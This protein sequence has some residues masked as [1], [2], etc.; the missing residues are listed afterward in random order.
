MSDTRGLLDR[1]SAFRQR[2]DA[3]PQLIPDALLVDP[4]DHIGI[5][6]E[7]ETFRLSL[8]RIAGGDPEVTEKP[9][10][11]PQFT[12]RA[13]RLLARAKELLDR[14]RKFTEDPLF[15]A[16]AG[17][18][19]PDALV[20]YHRE[21]VGVL[22]SSVRLAQ[23]FPDSAGAQLKMCE[24]L[25]GLL[26]VVQDR[27]SIQERVLAERRRDS[28][29]IDRLAGFFAALHC[30]LPTTLEAVAALAEEVLEDA[31]LAK[32]IRFVSAPVDSAHAPGGAVAFPVP[33]RFVAAHALNV[34]QVVARIV[35]FDYEW[36][37]RPLAPVVAAL[38]MDC[39]M[40]TVPSALLAKTD[41]LTPDDRRVLEAHPKLGAELL[42]WRFPNLAGPLAAAIATHHERA[43]GTGYPGGLHGSQVPPLGRL[44]RVADVYAALS[45]NR[46]HR[47]AA[48]PRA[49]LTEVL[50]MAE[51]RQID[52][53][54]AEYLLNLSYYPVNTVVE[55]TDGRTGVVV[56]NHANRLDPRAPG[57]PVVAVLTDA[58][59]AM[60]PRAEH[61]DLS[62]ADHGS[63]VKAV[64]AA[65]RRELLGSRYPDLV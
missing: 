37:A 63:I 40:V 20:D 7:A 46:P 56:A 23:A 60:L 19:E 36:A 65:R 10:P 51:Q 61:L 64:P 1:I 8:K 33:A 9:R 59:G 5:V 62:A 18:T 4:G 25:T 50:L 38:L 28:D 35:P 34:A 13:Q 44:L 3:T 29:R 58:E 55:L 14:Q 54:F 12:E 16:Y 30:N 31:R 45:E 42:L 24:G 27:L 2:L 26:A 49:A 52:R 41:P 22:D 48:D 6:S 17:G 32:P 57:R 21:T 11:Q 43:D 47:P 53:D 39:G 15:A